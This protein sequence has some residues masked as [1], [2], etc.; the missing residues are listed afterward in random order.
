MIF[1]MGVAVNNRVGRKEQGS[2]LT[3]LGLC[4]VSRIRLSIFAKDLYIDRP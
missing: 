1:V 2:F 4:F 3:R